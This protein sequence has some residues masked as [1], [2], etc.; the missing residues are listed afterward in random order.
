MSRRNTATATANVMVNIG[1]NAT[2]AKSEVNS[3]VES[4]NKIKLGDNIKVNFNGLLREFNRSVTKL[5][6]KATEGV[7]SEADA[8]A[9]IKE[10]TNLQKIV[11]RINSTV[12]EIQGIPPINLIDDSM[13]SKLKEA[14]SILDKY[15]KA[16]ERYDRTSASR[17]KAQQN[18]IDKEE[19]YKEEQAKK[20]LSN[21]DY[22]AAK[23]DVSKKKHAATNAEKKYTR[24]IEN[25]A[26]GTSKLSIEELE[27]LEQ[28][29]I[30]AR[31]EANKLQEELKNLTS[32]DLLGK[33]LGDYEKALG[34]IVKNPFEDLITE[35]NKLNLGDF[36]GKSLGEIKNVINGINSSGVEKA[37][38]AVRE[39]GTAADK[40]SDEV[41]RM[42][43]SIDESLDD[44]D[45]KTARQQDIDMLT[46]QV[47]QFFTYSNGI[48][49]FK[50]AVRDAVSTVRELDAAMTETAVVT[51]YS[52]TDMWKQLPVYTQKAKE[53]GATT[54][55][56][57]ETMTLYFQQGSVKI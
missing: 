21:N 26:K 42:G 9:I 24:E 11:N 57:Y 41:S 33:A 14:M 40:A 49:V 15:E 27:E 8:R 12:A 48:Q 20:L 2:K 37:T 13:T 47:R 45:R 43:K 55:G 6:T 34:K 31:K 7:T 30:D 4:F 39:I 51:D 3:L 5:E 16:K 17:A 46:G 22:T 23:K 10:Y 28:K 18:L 38:S 19:K 56:V 29:A 44:F 36:A 54:K 50:E 53:L 25:Y 52:I 32:P 1:A 35:L